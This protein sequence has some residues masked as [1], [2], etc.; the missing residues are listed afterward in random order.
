MNRLVSRTVILTTFA[1]IS[2]CQSAARS[3]RRTIDRCAQDGTLFY[4][5][6]V[7][8]DR[9]QRYKPVELSRDGVTIKIDYAPKET[10]LDL[11]HNGHV[12]SIAV[13]DLEPALGFLTVGATGFALSSSD[14]AHDWSTQLFV[15]G[16]NGEIIENS[17]LITSAESRFLRDAKRYC[18]NPGIE[19]S[20]I[21]WIDDKHLL[22]A[23]DAWGDG[24]CTSN[25]TE[26][27]VLNVAANRI[28]RQLTNRELINLPAVCTWNVVPAGPS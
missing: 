23:I 1:T 5:I 8:T 18:R 25:F 6:D 21:K 3:A 7:S 12:H 2:Y 26:G 24:E 28:E 16:P 17:S 9:S 14:N 15:F 20:A 19:T 27:F 22:I 10:H 4:G 13:K 11:E